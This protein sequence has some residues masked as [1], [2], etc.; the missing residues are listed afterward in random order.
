MYLFEPKEY[1]ITIGI[2]TRKQ[3][4]ELKKCINSL[5]DNSNKLINNFEII[6]NVDFDDY[7]TIDYIREFNNE[8]INISFIINSRQNGYSSLHEFMYD[9]FKLAKGKYVMG[10]GGDCTI[11]TKNWNSLLINYLTEFKLYFSNYQQTDENGVITKLEDIVNHVSI[12]NKPWVSVG[13]NYHDF[14]FYIVPQKLVELWG[15]ISP[16]ALTDN[17][18]G[19]MAKRVSCHPWN[20]DY[21]SFIEDIW[22]NIPINS[23][24]PSTPERDQVYSTYLHYVNDAIFFDCANKLA[25][26]KQSEKYNYYCKLNIVNDFRNSNKDIVEYF[27]LK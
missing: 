21:Y 18:L 2:V 26:Y 15:F 9:I 4:N 11:L 3:T 24:L 7:E 25:E 23:S 10:I 17:W 12:E 20:E 19:E 22:F 27:N 13:K 5:I 1:L 6:I 8:N 16:H 14:V